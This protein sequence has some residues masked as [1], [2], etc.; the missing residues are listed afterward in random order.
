MPAMNRPQKRFARGAPL[1]QGIPRARPRFVQRKPTPGMPRRRTQLQSGA[2]RP[3]P[4]IPA[5]ARVPRLGERYIP[6][7]GRWGGVPVIG[8]LVELLLDFL[9]KGESRRTVARRSALGDWLQRRTPT[10][11]EQMRMRQERMQARGQRAQG[12]GKRGGTQGRVF[13]TP[14]D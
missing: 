11:A 1:M 6:N 12:K 8:V 5:S 10:P 3:R 2:A 14:Q 13:G 7:S 4:R 9:F